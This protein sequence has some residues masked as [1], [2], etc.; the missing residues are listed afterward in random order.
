MYADHYRTCGSSCVD[1]LTDFFEEDLQLFGWDRP[2]R[3]PAGEEKGVLLGEGGSSGDGGDADR[4][5][6]GDGS[7]GD[8]AG[9]VAK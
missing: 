9:D 7:S 2:G 3:P 8:A 1:P 6:G 4:L 5:R